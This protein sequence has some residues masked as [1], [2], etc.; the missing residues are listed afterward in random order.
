MIVELIINRV[1]KTQGTIREAEE[2]IIIEIPGTM[3][4]IT[5]AE[6][7]LTIIT[8]EEV[9][10]LVVASREVVTGITEIA[11]MIGV[12]HVTAAGLTVEAGNANL[13]TP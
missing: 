4:V 2:A 5:V 1:S 7:D 6:A 9:A 11:D 8:T 10:D 13:R 12:D 3:I